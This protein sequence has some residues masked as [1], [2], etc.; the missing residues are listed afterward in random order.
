MIID[1]GITMLAAFGSGLAIG[2]FVAWLTEW[3]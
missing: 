3:L 1:A 2:Y